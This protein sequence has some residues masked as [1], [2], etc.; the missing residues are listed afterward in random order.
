MAPSIMDY[1][2]Q[3]YVRLNPNAYIVN[4]HAV[5]N[6]SRDKEV[7]AILNEK[8]FIYYKKSLRPT[9]NGYVNL[10]KLSY[11]SFW[12]RESWIGTVE[13]G[14]RGAQEHA[15]ASMGKGKNPLRVYVF[16]C[17]SKEKVIEAKAQIRA[18]YGIGNYSVH[19]NDTHEE[20][21]A[22]AETYFN[23]NSWFAIN[24]RPFAFEDERFDNLIEELKTFVAK[25]NGS[26]DDV[27]VTTSAVLNV[28]GLRKC[29]DFDFLVKEN[30]GL[31]IES[32]TLSSDSEPND[33]YATPIA[34]II[35]EPS[36]HFYFRGVKFASPQVIC[37]MKK[38]RRVLP[39]DKEDV[40][41][42]TALLATRLDKRIL[43]LLRKVLS[44][45][46]DSIYKKEK[47]SNGVRQV[48][49]LGIKFNYKRNKR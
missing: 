31:E 20:A 40:V 1:G 36:F 14:F 17:D 44:I 6:P 45:A 5:T 27:C 2:A 18:L 26:L 28:F 49:L 3:E 37:E 48:H 33:F 30:S 46:K 4:L 34:S 16:V 47:H 23:V 35:D 25:R 19:I 8:G 15:S 39:K 13:N 21:I 7:E 11:G 24:H 32:D 10:K 9:Y 43:L 22:L 42:L 29:D 12:E 41:L 38:R